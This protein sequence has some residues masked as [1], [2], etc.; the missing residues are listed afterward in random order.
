MGLSSSSR[1]S[2]FFLYTPKKTETE[3]LSFFK[4]L[5]LK[6]EKKL[7]TEPKK[8]RSLEA[9]CSGHSPKNSDYW[10]LYL[11]TWAKKTQITK[12]TENWGQKTQITGGSSLIG[13][14]KKCTKKEPG[15]RCGGD[16]SAHNR[17]LKLRKSVINSCYTTSCFN[18]KN[19]LI[20]FPLL[21][22][23]SFHI[24]TIEKK[25]EQN[26]FVI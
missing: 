15:L 2:G 13:P 1:R 9:L 21:Y 17:Q 14:P 26:I 23:C 18:N 22:S 12:K 25:M 11:V 19:I 24:L 16:S 6:N 10:R 5:R 8:L 20:M 4:K 7:K 3:K